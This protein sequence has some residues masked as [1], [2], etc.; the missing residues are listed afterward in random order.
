MHA[1]TNDVGRVAGWR[2]GGGG[3]GGLWWWGEARS[4]EVVV[5]WEWGGEGWS[6]VEVCV[7]VCM[8]VGVLTSAS[9][10][11][12]HLHLQSSPYVFYVSCHFTDAYNMA[13]SRKGFSAKCQLSTATNPT[14]WGMFDDFLFFSEIMMET[15]P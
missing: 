1:F 14:A 13:Y 3:G 4:G 9:S 11:V 6:S 10:I 8:R 12:E 5:G 7:F 2:W 15:F